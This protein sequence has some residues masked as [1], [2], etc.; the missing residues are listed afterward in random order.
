MTDSQI[1]FNFFSFFK[2]KSTEN[3]FIVKQFHQFSLSKNHLT[4]SY[5]VVYINLAFSLLD[6][7]SNKSCFGSLA[8]RRNE[9]SPTV[10]ICLLC[11]LSPSRWVNFAIYWRQE[12]QNE[13][14][15]IICSK[16]V[17]LNGNFIQISISFKIVYYNKISR[18]NSFLINFYDR[19]RAY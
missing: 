18:R 8:Y 6:T 2:N 13:K 7:T 10:V 15:Q 9:A 5:S 17:A 3:A 12:H 4:E 19:V 11:W 16:I 1:P 14:Y